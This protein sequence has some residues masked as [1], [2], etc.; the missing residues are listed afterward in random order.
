MR[1]NRKMRNQFHDD[2]QVGIGTM[3]VFVA[4]VLVAAIAAGVLIDTSGKLQER[5]TRTGDQATKQVASNLVIE[6]IVGLR[7]GTA[8][9]NKITTLQVY[10]TTAAGAGRIDLKQ[11]KVHLSFGDNYKVISW[12]GEGGVGTENCADTSGFGLG[13]VRDNDD[14]FDTE[15][16]LPN[17]H[18]GACNTATEEDGSAPD[19]DT[20]PAVMN[21][22]DLVFVQ[23]NL[24]DATGTPA[25]FDMEMANRLDVMM[26][27]VPEIGSPITADF[28]TPNS[29]AADT[30]VSLR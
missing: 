30:T 24:E 26:L 27:L 8:E 3:I 21:A 16:G 9:T 23:V 4:T 13:V 1:A 6:R 10:L 19:S 15:F 22:G 12:Q 18:G 14:S 20:G 7:D 11:L 17:T 2:A 28:T 5:S 29:F 25:G